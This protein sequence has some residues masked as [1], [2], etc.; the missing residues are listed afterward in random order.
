MIIPVHSCL[1]VWIV[2]KLIIIRINWIPIYSALQCFL[3]CFQYIYD[4][5]DAFKNSLYLTQ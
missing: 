1:N 4:T 2:R 3:L 5:S